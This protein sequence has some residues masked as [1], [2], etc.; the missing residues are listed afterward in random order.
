MKPKDTI[1]AYIKTLNDWRGSTL[2]ILRESIL[3]SHD[4][5]AEEWK[6]GTP[7]FSYKGLVC[8]LGAFKDHVKINFFKGAQL[9]DPDGLFN[10]GKSAKTMRSI[11]LN[12]GET[13]DIEKLK[14]LIINACTL[15]E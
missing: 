12:E 2:T 9:Q 10:S 3:Q 8:A 7:V 14:R 13:V 11:N 1:D 4:D 6:W 15:N 5:L